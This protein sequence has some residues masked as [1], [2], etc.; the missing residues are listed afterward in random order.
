MH[1]THLASELKWPSTECRDQG[2]PTLVLEILENRAY[3]HT[4]LEELRSHREYF[5]R[6]GCKT[7]ITTITESSTKT[8]IP[9]LQCDPTVQW[10]MHAKFCGPYGRVN[11]FFR[12]DELW[13]GNQ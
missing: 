12:N 7:R 5:C 11:R 13:P 8:E 9:L 10:Q 4:T 3:F 1:N 2:V 6:Q